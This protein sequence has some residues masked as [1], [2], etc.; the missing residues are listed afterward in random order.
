MVMQSQPASPIS[1]IRKGLLRVSHALKSF[2]LA[3]RLAQQV[4]H[5][6]PDLVVGLADALGIEIA[7]DLAEDVLLAGFDQIGLDHLA[8]IGLR[9]VAGDPHLFR[10]PQAK[11]P[12]PPR[13][14]LELKL[15][16]MGEFPLETLL[17]ILKTCHLASRLLEPLWIGANLQKSAGNYPPPGARDSPQKPGNQQIAGT[18]RMRLGSR[19]MPPPLTLR[20]LRDPLNRFQQWRFLNCARPG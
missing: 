1:S 12:V 17:A 9:G 13:G 19:C 4:R 8:R 14:R 20:S 5:L 3:D 10:R 11:Q 16:V 15:L 18:N 7:P 6:A 2:D